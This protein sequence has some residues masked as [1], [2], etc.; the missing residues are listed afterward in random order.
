MG[1]GASQFWYG[2]LKEWSDGQLVKL[3]KLD[4]DAVEEVA[5]AAAQKLHPGK[6]VR[7]KKVAKSLAGACGAWAALSRLQ[8]SAYSIFRN[9]AQGDAAHHSDACAAPCLLGVVL[10]IHP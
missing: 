6:A 4:A 5:F 1:A 8:M 2:G 7:V 3:P 10:S 9:R